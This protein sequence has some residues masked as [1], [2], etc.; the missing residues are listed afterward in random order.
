MISGQRSLV[1]IQL[2]IFSCF[3]TSFCSAKFQ[4][5][6]EYKNYHYNDSTTLTSL[7]NED[8]THSA[9]YIVDKMFSEIFFTNRFKGTKLRDEYSFTFNT[10][11]RR[12]KLNNDAAV[13][14]FNTMYIPLGYTK[15]LINISARSI[16]P[17]GS[18]SNFDTTNIKLIENYEN[19]GPMKTLALEG[20]QVGAE[21]EYI[22]TTQ[23]FSSDLY[24]HF[25]C[26]NKYPKKEFSFELIF[27]DR[28]V[29]KTKS[30]NGA[31]EMVVDTLEHGK[32]KLRIPAGE[33][34]AFEK[35]EKSANNANKQRVE[36]ML[37][38]NSSTDKTNIYSWKKAAKAFTKNIYSL[39]KNPKFAKKELKTLKKIGKAL[40]LSETDSDEKKIFAIETYVKEEI[41]I[42]ES[43]YSLINEIY[44]AKAASK[45]GAKRL[46][47]QLLE[48]YNVSH[49]LVF[50]SNR[51]SKTFDE[52]FESY[53]FLQKSFIYF[54]TINLFTHPTD[55]GSRVGQLPAAYTYTKGL[56]LKSKEIGGIKAFFPKIKFIDGFKYDQCYDNMTAEISIDENF[57]TSNVKLQKESAGYSSSYM[58][59]Y[60]IY[61]TD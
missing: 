17:D 50:T 42:G 47:I 41:R 26:Q 51:F 30:Y 45:F 4:E 13:E 8:T 21:I 24:G 46:Y 38:S 28:L 59:P 60:L 10:Y 35:E 5:N 14:R 54:P 43:D 11:H 53:N 34:P 29:F 56:F 23:A 19:S 22:Y 15:D 6:T 61:L 48:K 44:K 16:N 7:S 2:I 39:S 9:I 3:I 12:I 1:Q 36:Y 25:F 55:I 40:E 27:P 31:A 32:I 18:I 37:F 33:I 20:V 49:Q 58:G 57:E 52:D